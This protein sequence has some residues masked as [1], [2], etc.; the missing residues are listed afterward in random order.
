MPN[1]EL[2]FQ[3]SVFGFIATG[4]TSNLQSEKMKYTHCGLIYDSS[5]IGND[6]K[7][8][9]QL[10]SIGIKDDPS[11]NEVDQSLETFEKTV[12]YKNNHYEVELP[13][14][15]DWNELHDNYSVVKK[16]LDSLVRRV[17]K[18]PDLNLQYRETLH[19]YEK[20][21]IIEKVPN[22]EKPINKPV[23]YMLHQPVFRDLSLTT[24]MHIVF[25]ASS[26]H[27]FQHLSLNDCLWPG[28]NLNSNIF[29]ILRNFRLNKFAI[30]SDI[31]KT[32]LQLT[33]AEKDRDAVHFL[34]TENDTLQVYR[35][36]HVL[37]GV[38]STHLKKFHNELPTTTECLDRCFYV[39]DFISGADS[40]Q[41]ALEISAQAVSIMNQASM[42][43]RK[44]TRNSDE[45]RQLWKLEGLETELQDNPISL[46][47]K[48]TKVLGMLWNTVEDHL[49]M[50]TKSL[51][52][53]LSNNK[54]TKRHLLCAIGKIFDPLGLLTP[55]TIRVKC[56]L[57][58]LWTKNCLQIFKKMWCQWVSEAPH[59][60]ELHIPR[61]VTR[62]ENYL[63]QLVQQGEFAEEVKNL[64]KD[65]TV[66]SNSKVN[67]IAFINSLEAQNKRHDL[68]SK[69][70]DHEARLHDIQEE[71]QRKLEEK[72]AKEAAAE[73]R[74]KILEA[75]RQ[76]RLTE[77]QERRK[78]R[79]HK[80]EQLFLVKEKERQEL[81]SQKAR[82]K[83]VRSMKKIYG[84]NQAKALMSIRC[85][86]IMMMS[87]SQCLET[88]KYEICNVLIGSEVYLLSHL[89][90][91]KHQE[92]VKSQYQ[93]KDPSAEEL[94]L[95][96]LKHI[97]DASTDQLDPNIALDKER[98]KALKKR[99]K[100]LRQRMCNRGQ[101]YES[102]ILKDSETANSTL[103]SK[104][105]K[106]LS[107]IKKLEESSKDSNIFPA[108]EHSLN[109]IVS[110]YQKKL[111]Q[112]KS[113]FKAIG[114]VTALAN[115]FGVLTH[116]PMES[117]AI[118][119][120]KILN[121]LCTTLDSVIENSY[122]ICKFILFSNK[123]GNLIDFLI[124][125][126]N[127]QIPDNMTQLMT[128]QVKSNGLN[129]QLDATAG[130]LLHLLNGILTTLS[131]KHNLPSDMETI[132]EKGNDTED[133]HLRMQDV[134]SYIVSIGIVDKLSQFFNCIQGP[135]SN[136]TEVANFLLECIAFL[137]ALI[138][139]NSVSSSPVSN[140]KMEDSSQ[141][142]A[143]FRVTNL[144]G[145][146]SLLYG[147][148]LHSGG[149]SRSEGTPPPVLPKQSEVLAFS[150]LRML[151]HMAVMS[152]SA[153]QSILGSEGLSLQL[154]HI[155]SH[156]LWYCSHFES[157]ALLHEI[158]LLVGYFTVLNPENQSIIQAGQRPTVL[159]QL[160]C[161]PFLYFSDS[162][163]TDILFPTLIACCYKNPA[164]K[165]ILQ[166]EMTSELLSNYIE[167][168]Y[169]NSEENSLKE[170]KTELDAEL[171]I[172]AVSCIVSVA[173][174]PRQIKS[175]W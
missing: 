32:F 143:T 79:D 100:K 92:A 119:Q 59:P 47:V 17:K 113:S 172:Q 155:T 46:K 109:E 87:H 35:F 71:R 50:G 13:W 39:D 5:D 123:I 63:V 40:L 38:R 84:A 55:F 64:R 149:S 125:R 86:S 110:I 90:G 48:S 82:K 91:K 153:F 2:K 140:R 133:F 16:R 171:D 57:Q 21:G 81:A 49:I 19:D 104:M 78:M 122:D 167:V 36:N 1:S 151:N 12:R 30:I 25:D 15:R 23:F 88:K 135:I 148:L 33:L 74:R 134:I 170:N 52:D 130:K 114:G 101:E 67:E 53:S 150:T 95:Y 117:N 43:L 173:G 116:F 157:E 65:A 108:L 85:S 145:S 4:S 161:L 14:K 83:K 105:G 118:V 111:H 76:A 54:N 69:E 121:H 73:G 162:E 75:E 99:C 42:V 44:W 8:F 7:K 72:A 61:Y 106:I 96:N 62:A 175:L 37:F 68:I 56:I 127:I 159:Q 112:D 93:D 20:N 174:S 102:S 139:L 136:E 27:S 26:S 10:E 51:V 154:R 137:S 29:D 158:I 142:I 126:L 24:K 146:V 147:L 89:H 66:P 6:I 160:C 97:V 11:Y 22:P 31:E 41:D 9:W 107:D 60:S 152:L 70:K 129:I 120:K 115:I 165:T 156:L 103:K 131:A 58:V 28:P 3:N 128:N 77:M 18:N 94:E 164:N 80:V 169:L 34:W 132:N 98:Q 124:H 144:V 138:K 163:L 45:L 141:L 166:Q 168:K